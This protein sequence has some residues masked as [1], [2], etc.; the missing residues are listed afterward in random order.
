MQMLA[1]LYSSYGGPQQQGMSGMMQ[2]NQQNPS[3][4]NGQGSFDNRMAGMM[5]P[6]GQGRPPDPG[7]NGMLRTQP[8][9]WRGQPISNGIGGIKPLPGIMPPGGPPGGGML[10]TMGG[11]TRPPIAPTGMPFGNGQAPGAAT[12]P[13]GGMGGMGGGAVRLGGIMPTVNNRMG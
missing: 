2:G 3:N 9:P 7:A 8:M 11:P 1:Q 5:Q 13:G 12:R 6:G 4:P 10:H